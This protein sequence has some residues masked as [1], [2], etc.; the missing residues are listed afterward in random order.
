MRQES[1]YIY[2][3]D[4]K[5][6]AYASGQDGLMRAEPMNG[7]V[8]NVQGNN[9]AALTSETHKAQVNWLYRK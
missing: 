6:R 3:C 7:A 8:L 1:K 2:I 5:V 4:I 9:T